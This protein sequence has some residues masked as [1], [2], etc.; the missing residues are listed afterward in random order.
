MAVLSLWPAGQV[1][2]HAYEISRANAPNATGLGRQP[3]AGSETLRYIRENPLPGRVYS[4]SIILVYFY[5]EGPATYGFMPRN[6]PGGYRIAEKS[7]PATALL[8]VWLDTAPD[9]A[10]VVWFN[11]LWGNRYDYGVPDMRVT[12]GLEPV[13][14]LSDGAVFKVN[15]G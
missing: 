8:E 3:W 7:L 9:G 15:R 1:V 2:T 11:N 10:W 12:P 6:R 5:N 4:N 13:A 14:D